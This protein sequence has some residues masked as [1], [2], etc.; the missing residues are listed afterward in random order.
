MQGRGTSAG[1]TDIVLVTMPPAPPRAAAW[2]MT[3]SL[4]VGP[5]AGITGFGNVIPQILTLSCATRD[6]PLDLKQVKFGFDLHSPIHSLT[7]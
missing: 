4:V 6:I 3:P 1:F 5:A 7:Q 2:H